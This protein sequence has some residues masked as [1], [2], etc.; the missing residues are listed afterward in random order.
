MLGDIEQYSYSGDIKIELYLYG[1][2]ALVDRLHA[3]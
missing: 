3:M 2:R 1:S